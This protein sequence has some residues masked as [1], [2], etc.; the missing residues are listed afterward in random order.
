M[1]DLNAI[2]SSPARKAF[3][4]EPLQL[5]D[6]DMAAHPREPEP[7]TFHGFAGKRDG[8]RIDF[9]LAGPGRSF[10][11]VD[12]R[13]LY[14][15]GREYACVENIDIQIGR[16]LQKLESMGELDNTYIF[17][18]ADHGIAIGRHAFQ[19]KQNLYEH[20]WRVPLLVKGP[21]V[22]AGSRAQGNIVISTCLT[23]WRPSAT[24]R[25]FRP[26]SPMRA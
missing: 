13:V 12:T 11:V 15:I 25:G 21:G 5:V 14:E 19:G 10:R 18:T 26:R 20:T 4:G 17:Y 22:Q 8:K 23:C 3:L 2:S 24:S 6:L 16:V 7:G 9:I 1:G